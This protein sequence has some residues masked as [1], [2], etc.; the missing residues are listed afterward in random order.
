MQ[1]EEHTRIATPEGVE[2]E[3]VL[4]GL[5]S[6]FMAEALDSV[7]LLLA[8]GAV[9]AVALIAGGAAGLLL[10]SV[11]LG[12]WL[13]LSV[14]F[15]VAFE[16]LAGGR[17]PGK[18]ACGLR[19]VE[20]GGQAIGPRASAVRNLLRLLE[21]PPTFY[22]PAIVSVLATTR[23]QRLGDL[24]AG[25]LVVRE[26]RAPRRQDAPPSAAA[27]PAPHRR[28]G[29]LRDH[30][31][32]ARG[33]PLLPRPPRQL[34]AGRPA[35]AGA[36][37][38]GAARR[39]GRRPAARAPRRGAPRGDRD[40]EVRSILNTQQNARRRQSVSEEWRTS[41]GST[42]GEPQPQP[43][44]P[45]GRG[46]GPRAG[47]WRRFG[48]LFID[49]LILAIPNTIL[50]LLLDDNVAQLLNLIIDIG[51]FSYFEGGPSGQTLGKRALGIRVID[52]RAGGPI[53][54]GRAV[55]RYLG[56]IISTIPLFLGYFWMLWDGE[57]QTWHDKF[58]D[59]DRGARRR[60]PGAL[61]AGRRGL[62]A[63][64]EARD[65]G[66]VARR[67]AARERPLVGAH[68]A[69][70][71]RVV[72]GLRVHHRARALAVA[73]PEHVPELVH[74]DPHAQAG[75]APGDLLAEQHG[76][77]PVGRAA[78]AR[79][80]PEAARAAARAQ[81]AAVGDEDHVRA[82][83]VGRGGQLHPRAGAVPAAGRR[84]DRLARARRVEPGQPPARP[85]ARLVVRGDGQHRP[86]AEAEDERGEERGD[87]PRAGMPQ[88]PQ[89]G[90][91]G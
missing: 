13:L 26:P 45:A 3:L 14:A 18:R 87:G 67:G 82:R 38:R 17:T 19:V 7:I 73:Q 57:R 83:A 30:P 85:H 86:R 62:A 55:V 53:G 80:E 50:I 51:Y 89:E 68:A 9:V 36:R 20:E 61:A 72:V 91:S 52:L 69:E 39:Q 65:G 42:L 33:D 58:A 23:N 81:A 90:A 22:V 60:L 47:F 44:A 5:A 35:R 84:G 79:G 54:Y 29:R 43:Q 59:V 34:H 46:S 75:R 49:G 74:R 1:Y 11:V 64:V 24:A 66:D 40:G 63:P 21:G 77:A 8:L 2:L 37:P 4:A 41:S 12:G 76:H 70:R 48:A 27:A 15:H 31:G 6:R 56:R 25:T 78:D 88:P 71:A 28:V 10:L 32:G 16:V